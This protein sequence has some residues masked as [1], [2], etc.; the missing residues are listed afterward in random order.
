MKSLSA[1]SIVASLVVLPDSMYLEDSGARRRFA[2]FVLE[3]FDRDAPR[4]LLPLLRCR[5]LLVAT[6]T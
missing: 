6:R 1:D 5:C 3:R 4:E 2:R